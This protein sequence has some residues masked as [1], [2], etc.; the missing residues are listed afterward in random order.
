MKNVAAVKLYQINISHISY[1]IATLHLSL[2]LY[3]LSCNAVALRLSLLIHTALYADVGSYTGMSNRIIYSLMSDITRCL[4]T[5]TTAS[6]CRKMLLTSLL[7]MQLERLDIKTDIEQMATE[8]DSQKTY[9]ALELVS[10]FIVTLVLPPVLDCAVY[11]ELLFLLHYSHNF[12]PYY[13]VSLTCK[14]QDR[15]QRS[16]KRCR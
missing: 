8:F 4:V 7:Q 13:V 2:R 12:R 3:G 9:S 6:N 14:L 15:L 16:F 11:F 5:S 10:F 1:A